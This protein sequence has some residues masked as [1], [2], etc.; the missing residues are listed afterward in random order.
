MESDFLQSFHACQE[1]CCCGTAVFDETQ[2]KNF[3]FLRPP[4]PLQNQQQVLIKD[5]T[6]SG[7]GPGI[8]AVHHLAG[9]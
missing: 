4:P 7:P 8:C 2:Y 9:Y 3:D 1:A 6:V 5:D